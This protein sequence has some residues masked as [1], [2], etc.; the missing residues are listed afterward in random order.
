MVRRNIIS[1]HKNLEL[2]NCQG[3]FSGYG[4]LNNEK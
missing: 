4:T 2:K 1:K 3:K